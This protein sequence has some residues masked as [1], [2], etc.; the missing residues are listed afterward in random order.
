MVSHFA[1]DTRVF[2]EKSDVQAE[3][4]FVF[5]TLAL[6]QSML[7]ISYLQY[8]IVHPHAHTCMHAYAFL[9][10]MTQCNTVS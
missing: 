6:L 9:E 8:I 3:V 2:R 5:V 4:H 10:E 7:V 1:L